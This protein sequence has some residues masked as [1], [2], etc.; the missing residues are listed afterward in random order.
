[1]S[2]DSQTAEALKQTV[3]GKATEHRADEIS[4]SQGGEYEDGGLYHQ[5][6]RPDDGG[7]KH[8]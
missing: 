6:D 1:V 4:G 7:S 5:G 8:L 3:T 2:T